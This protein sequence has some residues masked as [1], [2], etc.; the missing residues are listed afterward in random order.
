MDGE[1]VSQLATAAMTSAVRPSAPVSIF[2]P[3]DGFLW[4]AEDAPKPP[5][6]RTAREANEVAWLMTCAPHLN[7]S[8][9]SKASQSL[10]YATYL[11]RGST[12][13]DELYKKLTRQGAELVHVRDI[14]A[15]IG[16]VWREIYADAGH[17]ETQVVDPYFWKL[18]EN[19]IKD[20]IRHY[21][22]RLDDSVLNIKGCEQGQDL[23]ETDEAM[24]RVCRATSHCLAG[25]LLD[26]MTTLPSLV[27]LLTQL[28]NA[29][30]HEHANAAK[31]RMRV[32]IQQVRALA[33]VVAAADEKLEEALQAEEHELQMLFAQL[34]LE[35]VDELAQRK[36]SVLELQSVFC[37]SSNGL[38]HSSSSVPPPSNAVRISVLSRWLAHWAGAMSEVCVS[39]IAMMRRAADL[40]ALSPE[41]AN[42]QLCA[43]S[44]AAGA[45]GRPPRAD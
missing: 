8:A 29:W 10:A 20:S 28:R 30:I 27:E 17:G 26:R 24:E 35:L 18:F 16:V 45:A 3:F 14:E 15:V 32:G 13:A 36:I 37:A 40:P 22:A 6:G 38:L 2:A 44:M 34:P 39:V 23:Q 9:L 43:A 21:L 25:A 11:M 4:S 33:R 42:V 41:W 5:T 19:C 12:N 1:S 31:A 7:M